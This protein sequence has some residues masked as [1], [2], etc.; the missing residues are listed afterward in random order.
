M[1]RK[2]VAECVEIVA[3][4]P[5]TAHRYGKVITDLCR[6]W[7]RLLG[8]E[9][10]RALV[11]EESENTHFLTFGT[12]VTAFVSDE[13]LTALKTPPFTWIG[14]ELVRRVMQGNPP[15]LSDREVREANSKGGL[16]LVVWEAMTP[17]SYMGRREVI[18]AYFTEYFEQHRGFLLK[19]MLTQSQT[20]EV[21][22]GQ[23]RSGGF[24]VDERGDYMEVVHRS[25]N[26][27]ASKPHIVG[28][29]RDMAFRHWGTWM[30]RL[31]IYHAPRFGFRPSERRLLLKALRGGTDEELADEI[32]IS[33]SAVK[34][35]WQRIYQRVS[36]RDPELV[37]DAHMDEGNS[38]RGKTKKQ[39]LLAYLREHIE[40]LRPAAP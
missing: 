31:F 35:A 37:P 2:D 14:P 16:N 25:L 26:E 12:C 5:V 38:E 39:H 3:A 23:L 4:N 1:R 34:K 19:E 40:E 28:L 8:R 30:S 20:A 32:V 24:L 22:E 18:E 11:F 7:L 17:A 15:L 10:F 27:I 36:A 21:M 6:V 33:L 9:A 29:S 13:F